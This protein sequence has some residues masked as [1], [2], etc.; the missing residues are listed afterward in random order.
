M[1]Y[2]EKLFSLKDKTALV[3]GGSS[4]IGRM[5]VE[6]LVMAGAHVLIVSRKREACEQTT[7]EINQMVG[8][9]GYAQSFPADISTQDGI[10]SLV[11]ATN[12]SLRRWIFSSTM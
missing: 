2:F 6:A 5:I 9:S 1:D 11:A 10:A 8:A 3:T 4:G 7:E 12:R